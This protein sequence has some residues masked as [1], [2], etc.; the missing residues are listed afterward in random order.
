MIVSKFAQRGSTLS[1]RKIQDKFRKVKAG[2]SAVKDNNGK[3]GQLLTFLYYTLVYLE[4]QW[5]SF[6]SL[7][8][9]HKGFLLT[10]V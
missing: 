2:Y 5:I 8:I 10:A 9:I 4:K 6:T 1:K 7:K 3:T